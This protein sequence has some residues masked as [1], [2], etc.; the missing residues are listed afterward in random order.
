MM[1][2]HGTTK[3]VHAW[4]LDERCF[5]T[6]MALYARVR[7]FPRELTPEA[8][9]AALCLPRKLWSFYRIHGYV[10]QELLDEALAET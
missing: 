4:S 2:A 10:T 7:D 3:S 6:S 8:A 5:F 9:E 1:T